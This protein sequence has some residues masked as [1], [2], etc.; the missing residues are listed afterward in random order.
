MFNLFE[1]QDFQRRRREFLRDISFLAGS[2]ALLSAAPWAQALS[3]ES[4]SEIKKNGRARLAV[5]GVGSR[6]RALLLN[7][8]AVAHAEITAVCDSYQPHLDRAHGLT[9]GKADSYLDYREILDR[10]DIDGVVIATPLHQH[11]HIT[12]DALNA[13]MHVFCEKSMART[14]E[15]CRDMVIAQKATGRILQIGH[16]R[17]FNPIYL[18]AMDKIRKGELGEVHQMRAFWH[19]NGDWRRSLPNNDASFEKR[20]NWRL[21][22]ESSAGLMTELASH[23]IQVANWL[24]GE[25]PAQVMGSGSICFWKDGREVYDHVALIYEYSKGRK[26]IYDSLISNK[27]YGLEEQV[28]G[29]LG[30][31]ELEVNRQYSENPATSKNVKQLAAEIERGECKP[32]PIGGATWQ[33]ETG[34]QEVGTPILTG[35]YEDTLL[36][37]EAFAAAVLK[38]EAYPGVLREGY[39]AS[40]GALL[41]EKAMDTGKPIKWHERYIMPKEAEIATL[42]LT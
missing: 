16:Q 29:H 27:K 10:K 31:M 25:V 35:E 9:Q 19:R 32:I 33:P 23:Q 34:T 12:I 28:M 13:G 4:F 39:H 42:S 5:I 21:Y 7:L 22:K 26:L 20:F 6:G 30:T 18:H 17:L 8:Q 24:F 11:K 36:Q 1:N 2:T 37:M 15:D 14:L 40:I 41:G 3:A 38:N